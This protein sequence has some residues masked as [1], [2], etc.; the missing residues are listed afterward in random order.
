M[1]YVGAAF[2]FFPWH[3]ED[4]MLYSINYHHEGDPKTWYG[5]ASADGPTYESV[6][7]KTLFPET[8]GS[9]PHDVWAKCCLVK[10]S[11]LLAHGVKIV[12]LV[13]MPGD[14]VLTSPGGYHQ[15]FCHG[16]CFAES[17]NLAPPTWFPYGMAAAKFYRELCFPN[18]VICIEQ[19]LLSCAEEVASESYL[20][21][22]LQTVGASALNFLKTLKSNMETLS[23]LDIQTTDDATNITNLLQ[24]FQRLS[25]D[26]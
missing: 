14:F 24:L 1:I 18:A 16:F 26:E 12:S 13:Q 22:M 3:Y 25:F 17:L 9:H 20:P 10:P 21:G 8:A 6:M 23:E 2:S 4:N 5:I 11:V 19:L 7:G 15:G